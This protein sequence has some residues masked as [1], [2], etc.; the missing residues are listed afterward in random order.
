V[1]QILPKKLAVFVAKNTNFCAEFFSKKYIKN[2]TIG[3]CSFP[4]L[5]NWFLSPRCFYNF[6]SASWCRTVC[7]LSNRPPAVVWEGSDCFFLALSCQGV[8][9]L[10]SRLSSTVPES[11]TAAAADFCVNLFVSLSPKFRFRTDKVLCGQ[12]WQNCDG[13]FREQ[14]CEPG[15]VLF[16]SSAA[17]PRCLPRSLQVKA[18]TNQWMVSRIFLMPR[19]SWNSWRR[20]FKTIGR[21]EA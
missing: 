20:L 10:Q 2:N 12:R 17:D 15:L 1:I 18:D 7:D 4:G 21:V 3:P 19:V 5:G 14:G 16:C 6:A 13:F 11:N 9:C 8:F